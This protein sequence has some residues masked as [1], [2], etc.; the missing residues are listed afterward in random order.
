MQNGA[1]VDARRLQFVIGNHVTAQGKHLKIASIFCA[2][3][4]K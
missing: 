3:K 4:N 2:I 1:V